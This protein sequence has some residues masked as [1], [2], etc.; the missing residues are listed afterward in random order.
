MSETE[1]VHK[2]ENEETGSP[3]VEVAADDVKTRRYFLAAAG[4]AGVAYVAALGYPVYKYLASPVEKAE[5]AAAVTEITLKDAQKLVAGSALVFKFGSSPAL[6]I[7]NP[8]GDWVAFSA[9]CTHLGC[10]VQYE[11][12]QKR[13]HCNCHGGNY[14]PHTGKNVSGPPPRPLTVYKVKLQDAGV[15]VSRA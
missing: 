1:T 9:V 11:P 14:D 4:A 15:V 7:H 5:S 13:I 3:I 2:N 6:L 8:E 10:T 12:D